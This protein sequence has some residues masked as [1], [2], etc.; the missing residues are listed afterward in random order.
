MDGRNNNEAQK[1]PTKVMF[2]ILNN[3]ID[4]IVL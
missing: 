4:S 1:I 3:I 2:V